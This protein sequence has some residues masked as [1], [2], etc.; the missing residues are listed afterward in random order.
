VIPVL[1]ADCTVPFLLRHLGA[2]D[3]R[4]HNDDAEFARLLATLRDEPMPRPLTHRGQLI[5]TQ[6]RIDRSTLIAERAVPQGDPDVF[7][8]KLYCNMLPVER[9]PRYVYAAE[10]KA[11]FLRA[12]SDGTTCM[13]SKSALKDVIRKTQQAMGTEHPFMPAFRVFEDRVLTFHDLDEPENPLTSVIDDSTVE[14]LDVTRF[15]ADDDQRRIVTSLLNMALSRHMWRAGLVAD[16]SKHQRFFFP[17]QDDKERQITW[18]PLKKKAT[19]TVAKPVQG[20][21]PRAGFW[22]HLGAYVDLL[23]LVNRYY[24][25]ISPTWVITTD[26]RTPRGGPDIGRIVSRWTG[27][28][29]NLQLL[30]HVR[31]W[32][33][34]LRNRRSGPTIH[35]LAGDQTVEVATVPAMILQVYGV[36]DDRRDLLQ[37]LDQEAPVL[38]AEEEELLDEAT[39]VAAEGAIE[40]DSDLGD[41]IDSIGDD[42]IDAAELEDSEPDEK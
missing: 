12:K 24:I 31:F 8:E 1:A 22:R 36:A 13:P 28:E 26:G 32:T 34:V 40:P 14:T 42:V 20:V 18:V 38:A 6:S 11:E 41:V 33:S 37:L 15:S 17:S 30:Y 29:R 27:P 3:L 9:L 21:G 7:T 25:R 10:V 23:W 5:T 19:R 16:D 39:R 4:G 2:V 35:I